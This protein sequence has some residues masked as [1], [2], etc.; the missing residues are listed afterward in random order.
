M[1]TVMMASAGAGLLGL[2]FL[3]CTGEISAANAEGSAMPSPSSQVGGDFQALLQGNGVEAVGNP[4]PIE[5]WAMETLADGMP[6]PWG[7]A[8]LP[9][10]EILITIRG[11]GLRMFADGE[12]RE[13]PMD[14]IPQLYARGQGGFMDIILH[15]DFAQNSLIYFTASTGTDEAA[16][17]ELF[18]ATWTG[19]ALRN[20]ESLW[21]FAEDTR[22]GA[23]FGSRMIWMEDG[24]LLLALGDRG[25]PPSSYQGQLT[26]DYAQDLG[27]HFGKVVRLTE[28]GDAAPGNPFEDD[29]NAH[30]DIWSFGHRN[31]Q[32]MVWDPVRGIVWA[33]EHGPRGGDEINRVEPGQ[34]YGWPILTHGR[35][36]SGQVIT[37]EV[38]R[39]G[40][41]DP[42][43]A[44][45][46]SP[47]A[48]GLAIVTGEVF[49]D[50]RGDLLSG[51]LATQDIRRII[52]DDAG[53]FVGQER[54]MIGQRVRD[55]REGPD[56]F[57][58]VLTDERNGALLRLSPSN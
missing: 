52:L 58:Y 41:V 51:G 48:S 17:T 31:I 2:G 54:L 36:Y 42:V 22:G 57:I 44:W 13:V 21:Q 56:G 1:K 11:G 24:H 18:R 47:G 29:A 43:V 28:D 50:W 46:P 7:M 38:T 3:A 10:G 20:I 8:W 32:G 4:E 45:V 39:P 14:E 23:H 37:E 5:G 25:N 34:N 33:S 49:A 40:M 19:D 27:T 53:N 15:P 16:R 30:G 26:R 35:E 6:H 55:V 12:L 9:S